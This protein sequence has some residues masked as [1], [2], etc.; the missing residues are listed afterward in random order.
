MYTNKYSKIYESNFQRFQGGGIL[1]GDVVKLVDDIMSS[2]WA[3]RQAPNVLEVI[4]GMQ[5][6]DGNIRVSHVHALRP[7]VGG[8]VQQDQQVD[9]FYCDVVTEIGPGVWQNPITLPIELLQVI[10]TEGNLPPIPDSSRKEDPTHIKP[11][12]AQ[13]T[14]GEDEASAVYGTKSNE[15]DKKLP[16]EDT[17]GTSDVQDN[18]S[19]A[20]YMQ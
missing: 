18:F 3:K 15:G 10:D 19:T 12:P 13:V 5:D 7:A 1:A 4:K 2:G 8:A 11:E 9:N 20:V 14:E 6:T 17:P 16:E